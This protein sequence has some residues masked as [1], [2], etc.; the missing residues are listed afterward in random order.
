MCVKLLF[1]LNAGLDIKAVGFTVYSKRWK[2]GDAKWDKCW[3]DD[4]MVKHSGHT[5]KL[6]LRDTTIDLQDL[7][8]W[9]V[10]DDAEHTE[11]PS[12]QRQIKE[13]PLTWPPPGPSRHWCRS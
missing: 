10:S 6:D 8:K 12:Q 13:N 9:L 5:P 4:V 1:G 7:L 11:P 2:L 3:G